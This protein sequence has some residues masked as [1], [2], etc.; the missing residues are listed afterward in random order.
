M[1]YSIPITNQEGCAFMNCEEVHQHFDAFIDD[2]M[3]VNDTDEFIRHIEQC[4]DCYDDL[5][6]YYM[7]LAAT[8][9]LSESDL[10]S[11]DLTHLLPDKLS[12]ARKFVRRRQLI[13]FLT[14]AVIV[15]LFIAAVYF[16]FYLTR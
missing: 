9:E 11:Y 7:V 6:V 13:R 10:E 15:I 14:A 5:E 3:S 2:E 12:A 1:D 16:I 8:G 4:R